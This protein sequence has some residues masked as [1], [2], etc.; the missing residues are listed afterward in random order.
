MLAVW[1]IAPNRQ[2]GRG[3]WFMHHFTSCLPAW[4]ALVRAAWCFTGGDSQQL[5]VLKPASRTVDVHP[6][7]DAGCV[8]FDKHC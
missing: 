2:I 7:D 8:G 3:V 1:R 6:G 5:P 4:A